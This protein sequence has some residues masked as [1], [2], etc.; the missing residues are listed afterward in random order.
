MGKPLTAVALVAA[1]C[2]SAPPPPPPVSPASRGMRASEHIAAARDEEALARESATWPDGFH[3]DA[4]GRPEL[5]VGVPWHRHWASPEEHEQAAAAH[6]GAADE[7]QAAYEHACGTRTGD[8][9]TRSP[10]A[11]FGIGGVPAPEGVIVFLAPDAGPADH[12]LADID[13]HRAWM[14]L[15][16]ADMDDCPLDL[17]GLRVD[18]LGD[19]GGIT[20]RI[21]IRDPALVPELQR[22]VARDLEQRSKR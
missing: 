1:A 8:E 17:P 3:G 6:R 12:L 2:A 18:A 16:P 13:C 14:M 5:L 19:D 4:T 9:V 22:R 11:R 15:A 7:L 10:I 21:T 20:L